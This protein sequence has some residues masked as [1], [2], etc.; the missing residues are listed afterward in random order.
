[1]RRGGGGRRGSG[2]FEWN[3]GLNGFFM[4]FVCGWVVCDGRGISLLGNMCCIRRKRA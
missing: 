3:Y 1:M 2:D 4:R